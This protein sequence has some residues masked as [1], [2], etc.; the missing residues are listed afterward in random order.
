ME[1]FRSTYF[2]SISILVTRSYKL[3]LLH[4]L[5]P[6]NSVTTVTT[7]TRQSHR[8]ESNARRGTNIRYSY[9]SYSSYTPCNSVT[10]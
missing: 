5:H 2:Y 1:V 9:I 3:Q 8:E 7:V 10:L 4:V 6:C